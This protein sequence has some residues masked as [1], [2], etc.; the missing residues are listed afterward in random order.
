MGRSYASG[1]TTATSV[2]RSSPLRRLFWTLA[3]SAALMSGTT[4]YYYNT[5]ASVKKDIDDMYLFGYHSLFPQDSDKHTVTH[6]PTEPKD[7]DDADKSAGTDS[8]KVEIEQPTEKKEE[9]LK[10]DPKEVSVTE[11]SKEAI[12]ANPIEISDEMQDD[13]HTPE[14]HN[15][16][17]EPQHQDQDNIFEQKL[18]EDVP[19]PHIE[20]VAPEASAADIPH[21]TSPS[22]RLAEIE[23]IEA[24]QAAKSKQ[25]NQNEVG[26]TEPQYEGNDL[27]PLLET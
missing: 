13:A 17:I 5:N 15:P 20:E 26:A 1:N 4:A 8:Q 11:E 18:T 12:V 27:I 25:E 24:D 22:E 14:D 2:K 21:M 23:R 6:I 9:E 7:N 3:G 10:E 19:L 16:S